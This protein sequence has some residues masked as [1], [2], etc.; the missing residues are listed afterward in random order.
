MEQI[1]RH[2]KFYDRA[3]AGETFTEIQYSAIPVEI[4][5]EIS[6]YPIRKGA[7]VIGTA[8]HSRN[9]TGHK[10]AELERVKITND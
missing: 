3:F 8:C 10:L 6:Y 1:S 9:I 2:K 7:E 4:W 5:S